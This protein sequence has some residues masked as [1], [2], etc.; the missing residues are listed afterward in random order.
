M[1]GGVLLLL[2][3]AV[4]V[5]TALY[6]AAPPR[7]TTGIATSIGAPAPCWRVRSLDLAQVR[8]VL[9]SVITQEYNYLLSWPSPW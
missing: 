5:L 6:A 3:L 4:N 9:Q 2:A 1:L 8:L 7:S